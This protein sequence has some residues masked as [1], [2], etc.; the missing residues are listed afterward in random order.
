M[1]VEEIEMRAFRSPF[2]MCGDTPWT[3]GTNPE[4]DQRDTPWNGRTVPELHAILNG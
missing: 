3:R 4:F 1:C 2:L